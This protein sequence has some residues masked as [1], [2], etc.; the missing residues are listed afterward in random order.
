MDDVMVTLKEFFTTRSKFGFSE[1]KSRIEKSD[2]VASLREQVSNAVGKSG[3]PVTLE[4]IHKKIADLLDISILDV[5]VGGWNTYRGLRKYLDKEK[6]PPTQSILVPLA[7]HT[8]KSEH[9]PYIEI[10]I[11]NEPAIKIAFEATL[12]FA[13]RNVI[14]LVQDGK[15]KGVRTGEIKGKGTIKCEGALLLEQDFRA[16]PLPGS[17]DLGDGIPIPA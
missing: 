12:T 6:Y 1:I 3:W 17:V 5:L 15:I 14:L 8:V 4:E 11:N 13:A 10:L 9:H 2:Q 16:I 7:E